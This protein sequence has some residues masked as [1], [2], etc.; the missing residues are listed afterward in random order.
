MNQK[1]S[2]VVASL[3]VASL[4]GLT[5]IASAQ[6]T[7]QPVIGPSL[8]AK[9]QR[10]ATGPLEMMKRSLSLT[11]EQTKKLEPVLQ[12]H[13]SKVNA[14]R[15][16][17]TLSRQQRVAKFRQLQKATDDKITAQLTPEKAAK[18][19]SRLGRG[20]APAQQTA[21]SPRLG[22]SLGRKGVSQ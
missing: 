5:G 22:W 15:R 1:H 21:N 9:G 10:G 17:T 12:E 19:Q 8:V 14:L 11:D 16:D 20:Q 7:N 2:K 18:W 3:A 6:T 4:V 13:Q